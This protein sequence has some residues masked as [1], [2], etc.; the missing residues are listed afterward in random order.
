MND[1]SDDVD[2]DNI[3]RTEPSSQTPTFQSS[4]QTLVID[5]GDTVRLPCI[6]DRLEGFVMMWKKQDEIL[7]VADQ[8]VIQV[9]NS[10]V[11][12]F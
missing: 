4:S 3:G 8:I 1:Q 12:T 10:D 11:P 5:S 9:I 6:V 2:E 7:T